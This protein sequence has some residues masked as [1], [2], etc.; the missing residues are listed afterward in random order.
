MCAGGPW[1][2]V[3]ANLGHLRPSSDSTNDLGQQ[4]GLW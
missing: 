4:L 3:T 1:A 2:A